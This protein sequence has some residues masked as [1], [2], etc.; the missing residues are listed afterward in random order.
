MGMRTLNVCLCTTCWWIPGTG[1]GDGF[2]LPGDFWQLNEPQ[3]LER[4]KDKPL[5]RSS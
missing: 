5:T 1:V 2:K 4:E 3:P